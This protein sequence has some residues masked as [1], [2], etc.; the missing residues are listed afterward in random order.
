MKKSLK[1]AV[2]GSG[3]GGRA[4]C[5]QIAAK[6]YPVVMYEPLEKTEDYLKIKVEKEMF[7]AGDIT[8]GGKLSGAT[9]NMAEA[10]MDTDIILIV[11]PSFAHR[12]IFEKLIPHLKNGHHVII[13]PGNYGGL[14]LKKM[15]ADT[16]VKKEITI[17]ETASLPYACRIISYNTVNIYKKKFVL[18]IASS[19][20]RNNLEVINIM[21]DIFGS[22]VDFISGE[23]LLGIDLDNPNQTLHPLPVFL[24]YG[25]IEKNP[26]TFR[27]YMDGITPLISEKM[28]Q[29]DEERLAIGKAFSLELTSTMDQLKMYYGQNSTKTYYEYVNSPESPYRDVVGHNVRSRYI[30]EDVPGLNVPA[31]QLAKMGAVK[32][33][34]I[35]LV[36]R[37]ASELHGVDYLS[38][39]TTLEKIGI[40]NT[41]IEEI[42]GLTS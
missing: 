13:I 16:G 9:M 30:T 14:L 1:Y 12:P 27:H 35:E 17:S 24:N 31:L 21:N 5:G 7:L 6:G 2:L 19:P 8:A 39:G 22:Y 23:N 36:V 26:E 33:P 37:L 28:M 4:I 32:T 18:K 10:V 42:I 25:N 3:H 11:V 40:A 41:A 34:I 29:M 38:I 15:M 20:R